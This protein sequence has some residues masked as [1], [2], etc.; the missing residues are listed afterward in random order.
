MVKPFLGKDNLIDEVQVWQKVECG[1]EAKARGLVSQR[2]IEEPKFDKL[3]KD[4]QLKCY[5]ENDSA[6]SKQLFTR[7]LD[8]NAPNFLQ[9]PAKLSPKIPQQAKQPPTA[10]KAKAS[11]QKKAI[12]TQGATKANVKA[13][14]S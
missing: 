1:Q 4:L 13:L 12:T 6:R 3:L 14:D 9:K 7:F 5:G 10:E 2:Q 8:E 11:P